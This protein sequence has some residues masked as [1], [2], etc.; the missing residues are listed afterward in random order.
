MFKIDDLV[1]SYRK[2][3]DVLHGISLFLPN[4]SIGVLLGPNGSGKSTVIKAS[5]GILKPKSGRIA[6]DGEDLI[7]M[8][9]KERAKRIAYVPQASAPAPYSVR[10]AAMMGR[11]PYMKW[12]PRPE[13]EE[14]VNAVLRDLGL[15]A[16]ENEPLSSLSGGQL[17]LA[18]I[19]RALASGAKLIA[20]DEPTS[21][22]DV[23]HQA[24]V[25]HLLESLR[26]KGMSFLM[27]T[28]DISLALDMGD[29]LFLMNEGRI[30]ETTDS[31]HIT[32]KM[33]ES[34]YGLPFNET[35]D[36]SGKRVFSWR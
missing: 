6:L 1:C 22:L 34:V 19:A 12:K 18:L 8:S 29:T 16:V 27:A 21:N 24:M 28:H 2:N 10:E 26:A 14:A 11:I 31:S 13:D 4:S 35:T 20:L 25:I 36:A 30:L 33:L 17:Q 32:K 5:C 23:A 9:P 3:I 7:K 15:T